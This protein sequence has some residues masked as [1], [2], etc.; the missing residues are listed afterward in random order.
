M[1]VI[2]PGVPQGG[3]ILPAPDRGKT[4]GINQTYGVISHAD[5]RTWILRHR[6]GPMPPA[7]LGSIVGVMRLRI[8]NHLF[9]QLAAIGVIKVNNFVVCPEIDLY[10]QV[11]V[12]VNDGGDALSNIFL[13]NG[14]TPLSI[15]TISYLLVLR[16]LKME[17]NSR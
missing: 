13:S 17:S 2:H 14:S 16:F 3:F 7:D 12:I 9:H 8:M 11:H 15:I 5:I 4:V 6:I 1:I 10:R